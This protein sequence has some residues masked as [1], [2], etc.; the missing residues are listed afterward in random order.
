MIEGAD[1]TGCDGSMTES[2]ADVAPVPGC[3]DFSM[4]RRTMIVAAGRASDGQAHPAMEELCQTY[5]YPLYAHV[6]RRGYSKE[7][8]EDLTQAFFA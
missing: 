6:R 1:Q 8:V 3:E 5:W 7:D 4:T 2:P